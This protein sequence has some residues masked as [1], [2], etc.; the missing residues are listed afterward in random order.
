M[1][2]DERFPQTTFGELPRLVISLPI[3]SIEVLDGQHVCCGEDAGCLEVHREVEKAGQNA[4]T[5]V[6]D[7]VVV[8]WYAEEL[9]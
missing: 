4:L 1:K 8:C 7:P 2:Q 9:C 3:A 6:C 5:R